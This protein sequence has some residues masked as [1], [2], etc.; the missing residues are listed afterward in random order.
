MKIH[1]FVLKFEFLPEFHRLNQLHD[2]IKKIH[3]N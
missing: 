1:N 3:L 2:S